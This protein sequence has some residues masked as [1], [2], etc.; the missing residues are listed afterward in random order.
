MTYEKKSPL[1]HPNQIRENEYSSSHKNNKPNTSMVCWNYAIFL[2]RVPINLLYLWI[3][4]HCSK[5]YVAKQKPNNFQSKSMKVRR[6]LIEFVEICK[7]IDP[8][9]VSV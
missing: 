3:A 1:T 6:R 7:N 8:C 2:Y 5:T 4:L 9:K